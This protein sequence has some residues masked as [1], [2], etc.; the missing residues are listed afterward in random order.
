MSYFCFPRKSI[1]QDT[2][3]PEA[4]VMKITGD[5]KMPMLV[6]IR[7]SVARMLSRNIKIV[8]RLHLLYY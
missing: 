3:I 5:L 7:Y 4:V 1:Q 6:R 8:H 2:G